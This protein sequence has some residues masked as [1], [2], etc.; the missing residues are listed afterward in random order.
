MINAKYFLLQGTTY[1][2]LHTLAIRVKHRKYNWNYT[3]SVYYLEHLWSKHN[4]FKI[5]YIIL[6]EITLPI[7]SSWTLVG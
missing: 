1:T 4:I 5:Y 6:I 2:Y 3:T 7:P